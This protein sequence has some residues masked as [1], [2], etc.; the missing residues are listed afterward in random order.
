[1]VYVEY[2]SVLRAEADIAGAIG[3]LYDAK[4]NL[5]L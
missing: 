3:K 2:F 4:L 5:T 1:M